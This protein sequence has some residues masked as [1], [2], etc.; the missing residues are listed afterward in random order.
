MVEESCK[1]FC[2]WK[3]GR[4]DNAGKQNLAEKSKW[5]W[6]E[7]E[8][9]PRDTPQHNH[10]AELALASIANKGGALMSAANVPATIRY[11]V[12]VKV[13]QHATDMDGLI[14]STIDGI[15][16]TRYEHWCRHQSV[17]IRSLELASKWS[18]SI[19]S[20]RQVVNIQ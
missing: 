2:K 8:H 18:V 7:T 3:Q 14:V 13:F 1:L 9:T 17:A 19:V 10:L 4:C 11:K 16:A 12:W 5:G 15:T 6:L 20:L